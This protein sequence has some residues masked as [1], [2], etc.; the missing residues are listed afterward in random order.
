MVTSVIFFWVGVFSLGL[1]FGL[2]Y[3]VADRDDPGAK[4]MILF[5]ALLFGA[6]WGSQFAGPIL[7]IED[8]L[9]MI[10]ELIIVWVSTFLLYWENFEPPID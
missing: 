5:V 7:F 8:E 3:I 6:T 1:F 2:F 9:T 10:T 4:K